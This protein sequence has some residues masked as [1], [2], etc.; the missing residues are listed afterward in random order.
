MNGDPRVD[1]PAW[2]HRLGA[3]LR[4]VDPF[5]QTPVRVPLAVSI[6]SLRWRAVRWESDATYRFVATNAEVSAGT[7]DVAVEAPGGEYVS[8][9]PIQVQLPRPIAPHPAPAV[10][11]DYLVQPTLWP[12]TRLRPPPGETAVVGR[13]VSQG[14]GTPTSGLRVRVFVPPGPAP[15]EPFTR[16]D[17]NGEFLF[18]LPGLRGRVAGTTVVTAVTVDI[19]IRDP[20]DAALAVSPAGGFSVPLGQVSVWT[21]QVP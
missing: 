8:L 13:V 7:F 2:A 10:R 9:A 14:G 15:A 19:E 1:S 12:T 6:P 5:T 3:A 20:A 16:T 4:F 11:A 18:R 21:F 17:A